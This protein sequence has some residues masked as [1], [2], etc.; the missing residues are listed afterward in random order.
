[1]DSSLPDR[2]FDQAR[3]GSLGFGCAT[4]GNL[5]RP[6]READAVAAVHA[7][8]DAGIRYF[9][10]A[11][12]YGFGLAEK[13]LGA[14]LAE[15]DTDEHVIISTKVGR[16]LDPVPSGTDLTAARQAF[17]SPEPYESVFDYSYDAVMRSWEQSRRRLRRDRIDILY[18]HDIGRHA[19]GDAHPRLFRELMDGGYRALR[20]LREGG[21]VGA[22]GLGVNEWQVCEEAL[23]AGLFDIML[24]AGRY[25]LLEQGALDSFLP[26]CARRGVQVVIG[27]PYNSGILAH[28]VR[29]PGPFHYEYQPAPADIVARVAA[30]EALCEAH[31]VPLAAAALQ[32]PLAHPQVASVIP[33]MNSAARVQE[34]V[35]LV[36]HPI[37]A[38]FWDDMRTAGLIRADAPRLADRS[39]I[40]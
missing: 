25:T 8:L 35:S 2:C 24:L 1:M 7:A 30:I 31:R 9:D 19:H 23:A 14:A 6:V 20:E 40:P 13:R 3:L 26:L 34:A 18:V 36:R 12:H 27:G 37:S 11:P 32:F 4:L 28:G 17:V 5:Y 39:A 16:R 29:G 10:V 33:G 21:A 15:A 38:S 22:I